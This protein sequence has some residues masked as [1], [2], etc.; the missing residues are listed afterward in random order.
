[1]TL[2]CSLTIVGTQ[3]KR[4]KSEK[5]NTQP[6]KG[7]VRVKKRQKRKVVFLEFFQKNCVAYNM[8]TMVFHCYP[9][10]SVM[11]QSQEPVNLFIEGMLFPQGVI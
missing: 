6:L 9:S 4:S 1:M 3:L 10:L 8:I 2:R 11:N 5:G 7:E